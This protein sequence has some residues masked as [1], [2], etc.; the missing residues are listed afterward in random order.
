M[1]EMLV[2]K[3]NTQNSFREACASF[4]IPKKEFPIQGGWGYT[5]DD[6]IVIDTND[7]IIPKDLP[8][9]GIGLEYAIVEK[10]ILLEF[11]YLQNEREGYRDIHWDV[12]Q[13]ELILDKKKAY[14]KLRIKISAL[15]FED[16]KSRRIEWKEN[17]RQPDFDK[18]WFM[19]KSRELRHHGHQDF[20]FDISSFYGQ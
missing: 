7:P 18:E 3:I 20:W 9:D 4:S 19:N 12:E 8:F 11:Y 14:D 5:K 17:G 15:S 10:R 6:A 16:W 1:I 2:K 13:Q